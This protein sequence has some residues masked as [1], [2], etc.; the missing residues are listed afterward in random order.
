MFVY[1][2][3]NNN[4]QKYDN[5]M[6][7]LVHLLFFFLIWW[8]KSHD[9]FTHHC[10]KIR[11]Y[12]EQGGIIL[13]CCMTWGLSFCGLILMTAILSKNFF[14]EKLGVQ[15]IYLTCVPEEKSRPRRAVTF[16]QTF[17]SYLP[18]DDL[19]Q[20]WLKLAQKKNCK[21]S[22]HQQWWQ[23][24]KKIWSQKLNWTFHSNELKLK[25]KVS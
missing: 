4:S 21:N 24:M 22:V 20:I 7:Y 16:E 19:C 6:L 5:N 10:C 8:F 1:I 15:R 18:I 2:S 9:S 14:Y 3:F 17:E 23:V 11:R 12:L 25:Q 13:P